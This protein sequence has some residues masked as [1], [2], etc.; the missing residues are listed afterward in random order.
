MKFSRMFGKGFVTVTR[1]VP[2]FTKYVPLSKKLAWEVVGGLS[3]PSKMPCK[4]YSIPAST[5][6]MGSLMRKNPNTICAKC[7]A[8]K[9]MYVFPN[10]K[11]ALMRRFKSLSHPLWESSM[12]ALIKGTDYFRWHD[13]GDIQSVEHLRSIANVVSRTPDTL[14]WLPT[15]EYNIVSEYIKVY[16]A[17]PGN[18]VVRLSATKFNGAAPLAL[19]SKLGVNASGASATNFD[20]P[21][22]L[23]EGKCGSCRKC[24]S[25]MNFQVNYKKH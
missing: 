5:C 23:Q 21:A 24:W 12:V 4:G 16:D 15:R 9:G 11:R 18:L 17:F 10:V 8:H 1:F 6:K 7:Y 20:C 19:A 3:N 22:S 13:S 2:S 14:H 25:H